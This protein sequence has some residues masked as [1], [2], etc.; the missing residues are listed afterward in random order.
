MA[1][2]L[3]VAAQGVLPALGAVA[4]LA[5]LLGRRFLGLALALGTFI[6][7]WLLK[8]RPEW[9]HVLRAGNNDGTQWW[10]WGLVAA[11]ALSACERKHAR[12]S[13]FAIPLGCALL[14]ALCWTMLT[15]LRSG[16]DAKTGVAQIGAATAALCVLLVVF[17]TTLAEAAPRRHTLLWTLCLA[18]DAGVLALGGSALLGQLA[19]ALAA[20]LGTAAALQFL[21]KEPVLVPA[22][23]VCLAAGHGG[24]LLAGFHFT[25]PPLVA[26]GLATLAPCL[27]G[28]GALPGLRSRPLL[29]NLVLVPAVLASGAVAVWLAYAARSGSGY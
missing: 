21:R 28:I 18:F 9:P 4:L 25:E 24:V 15:N 10:L 27:L 17:R 2:I 5:G 13:G 3:I 26:L 20:G 7:Y 11:G 16:W 23:G 14:G 12:R 29:A 6:A 1:E 8:Q 22:L 19:G